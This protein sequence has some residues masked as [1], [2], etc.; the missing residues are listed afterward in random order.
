MPLPEA[1]CHGLSEALDGVGKRIPAFERT[2]NL[3]HLL[4]GELEEPFP[5]AL[6]QSGRCFGTWG[7]NYDSEM[8]V[9]DFAY[10]RFSEAL[11]V[12]EFNEVGC[13]IS[14]AGLERKVYFSGYGENVAQFVIFSKKIGIS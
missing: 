13:P 5:V 12:H 11:S 2:E 10:H 3:R 1:V 7:K 9:R 14:I 4:L 8:V 6:R